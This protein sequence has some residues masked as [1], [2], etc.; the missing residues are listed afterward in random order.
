MV[1]SSKQCRAARAWLG[2]TQV[3]L[4][5][6]ALLSAPTVINFEKRNSVPSNDAL[7][8]IRAAFAKGGVRPTFDERGKA[9]GVEATR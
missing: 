4:A 8:A 7:T 3:D 2:W 9:I 5:D 6:R 1:I